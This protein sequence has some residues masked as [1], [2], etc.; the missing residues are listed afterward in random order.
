MICSSLSMLAD[1]GRGEDGGVRS[2]EGGGVFSSARS[3]LKKVSSPNPSQTRSA[4][5]EDFVQQCDP[6]LQ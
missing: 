2:W 1:G 4:N 5:M 6:W 3:T